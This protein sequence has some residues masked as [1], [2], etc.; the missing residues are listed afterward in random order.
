MVMTPLQYA[1]KYKNLEVY[2][3][4]DEQANAAIGDAPPSGGEWQTVKVDSYRLGLKQAYQKTV[5]SIALFKDKVRPHINEKD[6]SITVWVKTVAGDIVSKTYHSRNEIAENIN[7][8]FYGKGSPEEV[9][10]VLQLAVR[11]GLF[12][13]E[14]LQIYCD[15]GNIGLDCNGFV[16]NYLRHVWQGKPWA[17]DARSKSEKKTEFDANTMIQSIMKFSGSTQAVKTLEEIERQPFSSYFMAMANQNGQILDHVKNPDGSVSHGHIVITEP[18]TFKKVPSF[19]AS[20]KTYTNIS[21]ICV[22][23]STGGV[24]LVNSTYHILSADKNG[25]FSVYRGSKNEQMF[26]K[27]ARLL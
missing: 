12:P 10:I 3:Y 2:I 27:I 21:S 24:G 23:E 17:T 13:K 18:N 8:P 22:I 9:Q 26:V 6:E 1:Q 11:Y 20:G 14:K 25:T 19:S 7:D 4:T 5:D 15:N 16:G